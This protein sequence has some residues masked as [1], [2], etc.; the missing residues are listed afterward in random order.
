MNWNKT[1][2]S[3]QV[4]KKIINKIEGIEKEERKNFEMRNNTILGL[5]CLWYDQHVWKITKHILVER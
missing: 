5:N 1:G 3:V 2:L 4:F